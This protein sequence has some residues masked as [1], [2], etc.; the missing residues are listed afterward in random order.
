MTA[1][2]MTDASAVPGEITFIFDRARVSVA[3]RPGET[4]LESARRGGM[5]PPFS[6]EAGN[7]GTCMA[8]LTEGTATMRV[9]DALDD[10][11]VE[12]GYVLTCQA[13]PDTAVVVV[14]YDDV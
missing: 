7:C 9:N 11:E 5:T 6:C 14:D 10:D 4:L 12:D 2:P 8:K 3:G 13:V 1:E